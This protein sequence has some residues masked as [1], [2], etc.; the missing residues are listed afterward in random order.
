MDQRTIQKLNDRTYS[1]YPKIKESDIPINH[2]KFDPILFSKESLI[3][4]KKLKP[5]T[6]NLQ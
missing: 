1:G 6:T 3:N 5:I 4:S 2:T